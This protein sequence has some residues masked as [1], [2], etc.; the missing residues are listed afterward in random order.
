MSNGK[1]NNKFELIR[2]IG[3][4]QVREIQGFLSCPVGSDEAGGRKFF[5]QNWF[6]I[7]DFYL[8]P[9][10]VRLLLLFIQVA[11]FHAS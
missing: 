9:I 3:S 10:H 6:Q 5:Y 11:P 2:I 8:D 4:P 1:R 7:Q